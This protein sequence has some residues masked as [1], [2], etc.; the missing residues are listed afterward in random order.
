VHVGVSM[1]EL[2]IVFEVLRVV[3]RFVVENGL[4]QVGKI[5]LEI[6][7]LSQAIPRFIEECYPAA[8]AG[9]AYEGTELEIVVVP[10]LGVCGQCQVEYNVVERRKICPSCGAGRFTLQSGQEFIIKE[11]VAC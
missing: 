1:H 11:V 4:S 3:D 8:V 5:V 2:G 7:Q 9:T 10:A 6:G